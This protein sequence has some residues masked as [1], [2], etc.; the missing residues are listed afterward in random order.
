M[1][2]DMAFH[3]LAPSKTNV[4]ETF[5]CQIPLSGSIFGRRDAESQFNRRK[6]KT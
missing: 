1:K 2:F 5:L 3:S 6:A 4:F